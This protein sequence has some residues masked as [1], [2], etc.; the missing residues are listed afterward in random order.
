MK[1]IARHLENPRPCSYLPDRSAQLETFVMTDVTPVEL[2]ALLARGVRRFGPSYFRPRC[3]SC[4]ECV[5]IRV[6][7]ATFEPSKSQRR[8][9]R[10][11]QR[12]R[13]TVG[14]PQVDPSRLEL[15]ARWHEAREDARGWDENPIDAESYALHFAWPHPCA[16]ET[17][18]HD[19]D[20][21]IGVGLWDVTPRASSAVF[22]YFD[23]EYAAESLGVANVVLAIDEAKRDGLEHVYL[24]YRVEGCRSLA[25]KGGFRPHE[26]MV[27]TARLDEQPRWSLASDRNPELAARET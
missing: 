11:A 26:V 5:S 12:F 21:L 1:V 8:A 18:F 25:Y 20:R 10:K 14:R 27:G 16:R 2:E 23:P 17:T 7:V 24:G 3:V 15:Y 22:F 9:A 13:R 6:P 19:G 4:R